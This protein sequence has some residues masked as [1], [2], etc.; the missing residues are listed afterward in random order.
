M[1]ITIL[2][3]FGYF[4]I[5]LLVGLINVK[6]VDKNERT[7]WV[8]AS[9]GFWPIYVPCILFEIIKNAIEF[10]SKQIKKYKK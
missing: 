2:Y 10:V 9:M 7:E 4:I 1:D 6:R 5:G 3:F 8:V